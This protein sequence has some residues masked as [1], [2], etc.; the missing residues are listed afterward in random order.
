MGRQRTAT[1]I[2][3]SRGAFKANPNRKREAEPVVNEPLDKTPPPHLNE[4]EA[5]CWHEIIGLAPS[6]VLTAADKMSVE[7]IAVL[8]TEFRLN[9]ADTTAAII[10]RLAQELTKLGLNPSGRAGLTVEKPKENQFT[11]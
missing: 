4:M 10:N 8:M 2:L 7:M 9:K 1:S 5:D 11:K 3:E 6:G